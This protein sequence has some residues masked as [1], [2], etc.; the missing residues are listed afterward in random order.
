[1]TPLVQIF[2]CQNY[3]FRQKP[4]ETVYSVGT[5]SFSY[6]LPS[7]NLFL[8]PLLYSVPYMQIWQSSIPFMYLIFSSLSTPPLR[9]L[10]LLPLLISLGVHLT[11]LKDKLRWAGQKEKTLYIFFQLF[12][13]FV[14]HSNFQKF[15]LISKSKY[16]KAGEAPLNLPP[17]PSCHCLALLF[18]P[19]LHFFPFLFYNRDVRD[20]MC[21][22]PLISRNTWTFHQL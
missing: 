18:V 16:A 10:N 11:I 6:H 19:T 7:P 21:A 17:G 20:N 1:M 4:D 15:I 9:L 2:T 13:N 22:P 3:L 8:A 12:K 14:L 5:C